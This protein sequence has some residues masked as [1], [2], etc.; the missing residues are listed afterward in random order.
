MSENT[1]KLSKLSELLNE[2]AVDGFLT[3]N[4]A[5]LVANPYTRYFLIG[6]VVLGGYGGY[7]IVRLF[8]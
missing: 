8:I 7:K 5:K 3:R 4:M 6:M 2:N 1:K